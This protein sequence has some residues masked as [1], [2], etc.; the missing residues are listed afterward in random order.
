MY[1]NNICQ[2]YLRFYAV[3]IGGGKYVT[4]IGVCL[5]KC[6]E[7]LKELPYNYRTYDTLIYYRI[8][9]INPTTVEAVGFSLVHHQGLE[10]WTP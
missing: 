10:P 4:W 1:L 6:T 3:C 2:S 7:K 9:N 5:Q 8:K